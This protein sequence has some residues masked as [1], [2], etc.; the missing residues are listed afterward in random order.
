[1]ATIAVI[2]RGNNPFAT[3]L[4]QALRQLRAN[5]EC[6]LLEPRNPS[7]AGSAGCV[8]VPSLLDRS[9]MLPDLP[10]AE[11]VFQQAEK[12][13]GR[14]FIV[15]SSALIYSTG[16][17]RLSMVSE[18]YS[19]GGA[20]SHSIAVQWKSLEALALQYLQGR[21]RLTILRPTTVLPSPAL[22]SRRLLRWPTLTLP[23]HDPVVQ[24]LRPTDLA[25]AVLC[26]LDHNGEGIFNV[27][28]D[29]VVPLHI[30]VR[31][32]GNRRLPIPRTL[33]RLAVRSESLDY[34]RYPWTVS[35]KKIRQ[36]LGFQSPKWSVM[37]VPRRNAPR[38][39]ILPR[40]SFDEFGMDRSYIEVFGRT[41]F[42]FLS[43][44]YWRI[45]TKGLE[46]V[47]QQGRAIL[48]GTHRGFMP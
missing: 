9:G 33:Q 12:F 48:V 34:L 16:P 5:L 22:L 4:A 18:D 19:G 39:V 43:N 41:L 32:S 3:T 14:Q 46:H 17:G 13:E 1:M 44:W 30:A 23:G 28:P 21:A 35:N 11:A 10:E 38:T 31:V 15:L 45:E 36:E 37:A 26:A 42:R 24:F 29:D 40:P 20:Q 8:F 25:E 27:A 2:A 7:L 47:P 6:N